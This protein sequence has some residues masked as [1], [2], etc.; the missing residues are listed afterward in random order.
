ML[1]I[2]VDIEESVYQATE[3]DK[4]Q[5]HSHHA[6]KILW[7]KYSFRPYVQAEIA[8]TLLAVD[9]LWSKHLGS[10]TISMAYLMLTR[11]HPY[12]LRTNSQKLKVLSLA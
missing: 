5:E 11:T 2:S 6:S 8:I 3:Q 1:K 12:K 7:A 4:G 10:D 9:L